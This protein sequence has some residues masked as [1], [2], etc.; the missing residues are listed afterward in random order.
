LALCLL[1]YLP[2]ALDHILA[3]FLVKALVMALEMFFP[4]LSKLFLE[5]FQP[6]PKM[7]PVSLFLFPTYHTFIFPFPFY[8]FL[9]IIG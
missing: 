1:L 5:I 4:E 7:V 2:I 3:L 6:S 8:Y 9:G